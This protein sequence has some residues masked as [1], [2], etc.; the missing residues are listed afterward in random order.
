VTLRDGALLQPDQLREFLSVRFAKWQLP[1]A[2]V[3]MEELPHT[4]TGKLLKAEL[5]RRFRDWKWDG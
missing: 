1:D 5:R 4:S 3:S 2:F